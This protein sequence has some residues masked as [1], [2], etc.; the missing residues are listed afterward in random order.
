MLTRLEKLGYDPIEAMI[1]M[2]KNPKISDKIRF[3]AAK[4]IASF[5]YPR[6]RSFDIRVEEKRQEKLIVH[7]RTF[8]KDNL[9]GAPPRPPA[10]PPPL[11]QSPVP[12]QLAQ[13]MSCYDRDV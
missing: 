9:P 8:D 2:A 7:I 5:V 11:L 3:S 13:P 4:E 12:Q 6:M 1:L 10:L